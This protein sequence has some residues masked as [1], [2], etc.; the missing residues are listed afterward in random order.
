[1]LFALGVIVGFLVCM[2]IN[3]VLRAAGTLKID[4]SN[5]DK[6]QYLFEIKDLDSLAKK[7][8]IVLKIDN[9]ADLSQK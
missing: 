3:T 5:P 8:K 1:M 4:R 6:D 7:K 9:K 2:L